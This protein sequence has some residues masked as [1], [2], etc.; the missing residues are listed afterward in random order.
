[1]RGRRNT[2]GKNIGYITEITPKM[3]ASAGNEFDSIKTYTF[4]AE[5]CLLVYSQN[6]DPF[7]IATRTLLL[8]DSRYDRWFKKQ[9]KKC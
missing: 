7:Y 5:K 2:N 1:M 8:N 9:N 4:Y 3:Y 6:D